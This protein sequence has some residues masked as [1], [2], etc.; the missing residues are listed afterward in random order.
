LG[1]H[2]FLSHLP[3]IA[4]E[5]GALDAV[6]ISNRSIFRS[7]DYK[8][9]IWELNPYVD[10]FTDVPGLHPIVQKTSEGTNILDE[11][12][13]ALGLDDGKRFHE[14]EIYY[15]P[16][17]RNELRDVALYDPNYVSFVGDVDSASLQ[18]FLK[19]S[20]VQ[21]DAVMKLR[22]KHVPLPFIKKEVGTKSLEEFC[23]IIASC[24]SLYCLGSGTATLAAALHKPATVFYGEGH[25]PIFHHSV[26]HHYIQVPLIP[27]SKVKFRSQKI[28]R[29]TLKPFVGFLRLL[30]RWKARS[31]A[32]GL[33]EASRQAISEATQLTR[34]WILRR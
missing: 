23:D 7:N 22:D 20:G 12:M 34:D 28:V 11:W 1:D 17:V 15:K 6:Y 32:M 10:G 3:R 13:L 24:K 26:L 16:H 14:P 21:I 33:N 27:L 30:G 18:K 25:N 29:A 31:K 8:R 9:L 2:L 5:S 19:R 4:K